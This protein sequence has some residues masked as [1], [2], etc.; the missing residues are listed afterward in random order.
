MC[1]VLGGKD[2]KVVWG[3]RGFADL[4]TIARNGSNA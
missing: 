1:V 2:V 3:C 4:G